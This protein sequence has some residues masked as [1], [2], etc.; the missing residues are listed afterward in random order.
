[1]NI[2]EE[3]YRRIWCGDG[4]AK[5]SATGRQNRAEGKRFENQIDASLLYYHTKGLAEIQKTPEPVKVLGKVDN[6]GCFTACFEKAAQPD[7]KGVLK[8]GRCIVFDAKHTRQDRIR[9]SA[10]TD[11]QAHIL[12][13]YEKMGAVCCIVCEIQGRYFTVDWARW[14]R[15]EKG[16]AYFTADDLV[17]YE[18]PCRNGIVKILYVV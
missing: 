14:K 1:M 7:Y 4:S 18:V 15:A 8:G 10:V 12:D 6:R 9:K 11:E 16:H 17:A 5:A 2:S 13:A 3:E